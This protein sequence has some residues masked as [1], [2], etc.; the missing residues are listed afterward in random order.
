M[1]IPAWLLDVDDLERL[2]SNVE[3]YSCAL[4][5]KKAVDTIKYVSDGF[6]DKTIDR[7][8]IYYALT[9]QGFKSELIKDAYKSVDL[10]G[11]TDDASIA[12]KCGYK[13]KI[14]ECK[15]DN[16]KLTLKED[17][18]N[19]FDECKI[20]KIEEIKTGFFHNL[21]DNILRLI[22]PLC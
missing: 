21:I 1:R 19:Y 16:R 11:I 9:P 4:L 20:V 8:H 13:V 2:K 3:E 10:I 18:N 15:S 22:A 7:E 14:V 6:I 12:E 17:F 5:A